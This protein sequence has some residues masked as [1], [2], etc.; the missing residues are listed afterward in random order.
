[1]KFR[2]MGTELLRGER[3]RATM[4]IIVTFCKFAKRC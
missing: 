1:M 3:Q 4:K 2:P